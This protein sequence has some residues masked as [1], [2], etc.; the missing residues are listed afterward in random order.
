MTLYPI[1]LNFLIFLI[2]KEIVVYFNSVQERGERK[3]SGKEKRG[4]KGKEKI[5]RKKRKGK[6]VA[7][8][9]KRDIK[10]EKRRGERRE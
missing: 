1:H 5:L 6:R 3:K 4:K 7:E 9:R 2:Y 10:D 8:K